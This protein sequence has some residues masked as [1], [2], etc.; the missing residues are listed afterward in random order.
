MM[1]YLV[2]LNIMTKGVF[3]NTLMLP[4]SYSEAVINLQNSTDFKQIIDASIDGSL[5][6]SL[7]LA[8]CMSVL[9]LI[10]LIIM[11]F[12]LRSRLSLH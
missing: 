3:D 11:F 6:T 1:N 10:L 9:I 5:K 12:F 7:I 4:L 2:D 8:I